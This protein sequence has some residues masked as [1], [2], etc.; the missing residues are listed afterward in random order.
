MNNE[1]LGELE[2]LNAEGAYR[3][4]DYKTYVIIGLCVVIVILIIYIYFTRSSEPV[5]PKPQVPVAM[6][7]TKKQAENLMKNFPPVEE[8]PVPEPEPEP[9]KEEPTEVIN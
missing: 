3:K 6:P 5:E 8:E 4:K 1:I 7:D 2:P 9:E